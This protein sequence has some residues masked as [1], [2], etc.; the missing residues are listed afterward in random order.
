MTYYT[1][2][3]LVVLLSVMLV[4]CYCEGKSLKSSRISESK[5]SDKSD[6]SKMVPVIL[7]EQRHK[8]VNIKNNELTIIL[9]TLYFYNN[10]KYLFYS[11]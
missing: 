9:F 6:G 2:Q 3:S 1:K 11:I 4:I 8:K 7:K 5:I 10:L